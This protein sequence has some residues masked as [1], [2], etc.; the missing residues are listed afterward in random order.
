MQRIHRRDL[1]LS[2]QR[3][4]SYLDLLTSLSWRVL[5]SNRRVAVSNRIQLTGGDDCEVFQYILHYIIIIDRIEEQLSIHTLLIFSFH[6]IHYETFP[7]RLTGT[8]I[9]SPCQTLSLSCHPFIR[10][11]N[12]ATISTAIATTAVG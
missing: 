11:L 4:Q 8:L 6:I 12:T 9:M 5:A 1:L 7:S 3:I 10:I 2:E